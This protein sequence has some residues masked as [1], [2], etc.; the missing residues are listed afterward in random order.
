MALENNCQNDF[1]SIDSSSLNC[2]LT[3]DDQVA[4]PDPQVHTNGSRRQ[5]TGAYKLQMIN[6]YDACTNGAER[7]AL[8]RKEALYYARIADWRRQ[9]GLTSSQNKSGTKSK[10]TDHL[11]REIEQLKKK[12]AQAE[13]IIHLQKKVSEL[14][15]EHI[16]PLG[17]N[18]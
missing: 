1:S 14:L 2:N 8:L 4:K 6:A 18:G 17:S 16:L 10:R 9:L 12:L 7:A 3:K 15:G 13:A 11:Q 5:F